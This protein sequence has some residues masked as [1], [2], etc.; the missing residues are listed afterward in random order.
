MTYKPIME[1]FIVKADVFG[2]EF[3]STG[4]FQSSAIYFRPTRLPHYLMSVDRNLY[5]I[6]TGEAYIVIVT[7]HWTEAINLAQFGTFHAASELLTFA[8]S[9]RVFFDNLKCEDEDRV[10]LP[11]RQ[12]RIGLPFAGEER[13]SPDRVPSFLERTLPKFSNRQFREKTRVFE[14]ISWLNETILSAGAIEELRFTMLWL[15]LDTLVSA[16]L[17]DSP[18]GKLLSK[19]EMKSF[20]RNVTQ[21]SSKHLSKAK[22]EKLL[23]NLS[24]LNEGT[25]SE[26]IIRFLRGHNISFDKKSIARIVKTRNIIH[27]I[28]WK[29][30]D[31]LVPVHARLEKLVETSIFSVLE[32]DPVQYLVSQAEH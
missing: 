7:P 14:A 32:V 16:S 25:A 12:T 30:R 3:P 29:A 28:P 11:E 15:A 17:A 13:I 26:K 8:Q 2:F 31:S 9:R 24:R 19:G 21:W 18:R 4:P 23:A 5:H 10:F 22:A 6:K 1:W 20:R 27:H